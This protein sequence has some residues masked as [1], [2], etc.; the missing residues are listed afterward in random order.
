MK[1]RFFQYEYPTALYDHEVY[2]HQAVVDEYDDDIYGTMMGL[3]E[4]NRPN[5]EL[6]KQQPYLTPPIR[7]KLIDFL[8]KMAVRLKILPFVFYKAVRIFDR[9]CLKRIVLLDQLQLIITTCLWIAAKVQG[10]NNHFV[11]LANLDRVSCIKTINDVGYGA[12]GKYL[13]PTERF[14]LP[15]LH[16]LVKLCGAKCKYDQGMFKQMELHV[17]TT[18][19]WLLN[20]PGIEE[21]LVLLREFTVIPLLVDDQGIPQQLLVN[22]MFKIKEFLSYVALYLFELVDTHTVH[23]AHV[24]CDLINE[25]FNLQPGHPCHQHVGQMLDHP[26]ATS[27]LDFA[28]YKAVKKQLI[29]LV[30]ALTEFVLKLFG[31]KGPQYLYHQVCLHYKFSLEPVPVKRTPP[32]RVAVPPTPAPATLPDTKKLYPFTPPQYTGY[33]P[34]GL[35][36]LLLTVG[37]AMLGLTMTLV[38]SAGLLALPVFAMPYRRDP[39]PQKPR[40]LLALSALLARGYKVFGL[41]VHPHHHHY[42]LTLLNSLASLQGCDECGQPNDLFEYDYLRRHAMGTPLLE[43]DSPIFTKHP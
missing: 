19:E 4:Q 25:T 23:V 36:A 20:D 9:Y 11:N 28:Q 13:G 38:L 30:L 10:G 1:A 22:E 2:H 31:S 21:F 34:V 29:R 7:L 14:R 24:I 39:S 15:K 3:I 18:L 27:A 6:Y 41:F 35:A 43:N 42:L 8:L 5:V 12:G 33:H 16:E 17:L 26:L 37:L 32:C 40:G